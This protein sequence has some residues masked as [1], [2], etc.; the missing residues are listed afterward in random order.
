MLPKAVPRARVL[1]W[2]YNADVTAFMGNT[3]S[4]LIL[5]HAQTLIAQL[6]ADREVLTHIKRTFFM[7]TDMI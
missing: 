5:Q 3:S 6:Q 4:D 2:G 1:T 7:I